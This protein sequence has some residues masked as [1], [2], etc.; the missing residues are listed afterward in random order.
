M[1]QDLGYASLRPQMYDR[2]SRVERARR[3]KAVLED[4]FG[5]KRLCNLRALDVGSSTGIFD[6]ELVDGLE[7]LVGVDVD[8]EAVKYAQM[9]FGSK[10]LK[11]MVGSGMNLKFKD[12]TFDL[13]ICCQT[14][15]HVSDPQKLFREIYRVL[16]PHGVCYLTAMNK[17]WIWEPHHSLPFL[18]W[19]PKSWVKWYKESPKSYWELK[20]ITS[21]FQLMDYTSKILANPQ[22]Y[23]YNFPKIIPPMA[24]IVKLFSPTFIWILQK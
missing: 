1:K 13:V 15:E 10:R 16:K 22:K 18:S 4:C 11:F 9:N 17:W 12:N 2:K 6:D 5:K 23:Y 7:S 3:A 21:K 20:A 14:Y 19:L 8:G 24:P